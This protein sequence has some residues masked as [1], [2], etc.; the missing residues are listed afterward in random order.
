MDP[1]TFYKM[2]SFIYA[3]LLGALQRVSL[4]HQLLLH[5]IRKAEAQ[6]TG[7]LMMADTSSD[8]DSMQESASIREMKDEEQEGEEYEGFDDQAGSD[9]ENAGFSL[10]TSTPGATPL[11][12]TIGRKRMTA[13][14]GSKLGSPRSPRT[15]FSGGPMSPPVN[16]FGALQIED[17]DGQLGV[18]A[19][20][21]LFRQLETE[22]EEILFAVADLA[23]SRCA[24]LM[25]MRSEQSAK[26]LPAEVYKLLKLTWS[27]VLQS[28]LLSGYM[29]YGLRTAILSQVCTVPMSTATAPRYDSLIWVNSSSNY[30][31]F[32][33]I[34]SKAFLLQFHMEKTSQLALAV[35]EDQWAQV[36][37]PWSSQSTANEITAISS[38][39][40]QEARNKDFTMVFNI[41]SLSAPPIQ[42]MDDHDS[43][44]QSRL[45]SKGSNGALSNGKGDSKSAEIPAST[46]VLS[47]RD[48]VFFVVGCSLVLL[49]ILAEYLDILNNITALTTDVMQRIIELLKVTLQFI[50]MST[51]VTLLLL[52]VFLTSCILFL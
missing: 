40:L 38:L 36:E 43:F 23:H 16:R 5:C 27:F 22:S 33:F 4:Y 28:E 30:L 2:L 51:E 15:P 47:I 6:G 29:C 13:Q 34:Q 35:G 31:C 49:D 17:E 14:S 12:A 24:K 3:F 32:S 18:N 1:V 10:G 20:A 25:G 19:V 9:G 37:V 41:L 46:R 8:S 39:S 48:E 42:G 44:I 50:R 7:D 21:Q 11:Q 45:G 26:L 52:L